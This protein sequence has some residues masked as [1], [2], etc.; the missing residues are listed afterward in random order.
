MLPAQR[1]ILT[2]FPAPGPAAGILAVILVFILVLVLLGYSPVLAVSVVIAVT[3]AAQG[4]APQGLP[5][6]WG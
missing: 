4:K 3:A 5:A 2:C 6:A 1:S